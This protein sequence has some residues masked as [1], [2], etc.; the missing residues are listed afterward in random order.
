MS[1]NSKENNKRMK[2]DEFWTKM[3]DLRK[4]YE[5]EKAPG[6]LASRVI[7]RLSQKPADGTDWR[8]AQRKLLDVRVLAPVFAVLVVLPLLW[9]KVTTKKINVTFRRAHRHRI[10]QL[11]FIALR[12]E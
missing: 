1:G 6:F 9:I 7:S 10:G 4:D 2:E 11:D 3:E 8:Q 5:K 12:G